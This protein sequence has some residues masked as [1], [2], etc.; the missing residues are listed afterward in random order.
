VLAQVDKINNGNPFV[1][2]LKKDTRTKISQEALEKFLLELEI[3]RIKNEHKRI[4]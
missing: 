1:Y 4:R 3:K 2:S